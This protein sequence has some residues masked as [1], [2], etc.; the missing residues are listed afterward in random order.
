MG[1]EKSE[2]DNI[3]FSKITVHIDDMDAFILTILFSCP[4]SFCALFVLRNHFSLLIQ[5]CGT[6]NLRDSCDRAYVVPKD[7]EPPRTVDVMRLL[8]FYAVDPLV[9]SGD[10]KPPGR[11]LAEVCARKLLSKLVELSES[12][13]TP[14][15]LKQTVKALSAEKKVVE[16]LDYNMSTD[17]DMKRGDWMCPK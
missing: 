11:E 3:I 2:L 12:T 5:V 17:V 14:A 6:C 8:M 16:K 13:P 4:F 9:T 10:Q 7:L 1:S 15:P